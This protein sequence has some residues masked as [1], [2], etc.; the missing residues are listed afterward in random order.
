M[1]RALPLVWVAA[2]ALLSPARAADKPR[3]SRGTPVVVVGRITS[4]PKGA[5]EEQKMQVAIG[6]SKTDYTLHFRGADLTGLHGQKIDEDGLDD[7]QWV[8]AEGKVMDDP[9]RVKVSRLQVIAPDDPALKRSAFYRSGF[10]QGYVTSVAGSRQVFFPTPEQGIVST[11]MPFVLVGRVSDDTGNFE[12]SRKIQVK[13]A[14]NEWTL[15]VPKDASVLDLKGEKISVHEV[16]DGQWVRAYG[17]RTDDLRMRAERM[18]NIGKDEAFR[19]SN[20][21]RSEFPLGYVDP[22]TDEKGFNAYSL[23]GT[24]VAVHRADGT[25]LV[26]DAQGRE[27][28][29]YTDLGRF[30]VDGRQVTYDRLRVGDRVTVEGRTF[31]F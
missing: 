31:R 28:L 20:L 23:S 10:D 14:G 2:F 24:V 12:R 27:H 11:A 4:P 13:S 26:R 16:H 3:F 22:F 6:P 19:A 15:H 21:Y 1:A 8:R 9:R 7:G 25:A 29:V 18:E 5:L 30:S 17:W